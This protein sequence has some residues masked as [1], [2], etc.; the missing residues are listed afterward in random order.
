MSDGDGDDNYT[1]DDSDVCA[2]ANPHT[3]TTT[4]APRE[5]VERERGAGELVVVE[6][7]LHDNGDNSSSSSSKS[8]RAR[9]S[10]SQSDSTSS[11]TSTPSSST[12]AATNSTSTPAP[13]NGPAAVTSTT[14]ITVG[15]SPTGVSDGAQIYFPTSND[16]WVLN[17][18]VVIQWAPALTVPVDII[19]TNP[20]ERI[21]PYAYY[22]SSAVPP[23]FTSM[24]LSVANPAIPGPGYMLTLRDSRNQSRDYAISE[25]F[26]IRRSGAKPVVPAGF[27]TITA[28]DPEYNPQ[29][30]GSGAGRAAGPGLLAA[31]GAGAIAAAV[32]WTL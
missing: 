18:G 11:E 1:T 9:S 22:M 14:L 3:H 16:W 25:P 23:G 19:L 32:A 17:A 29:P 4:S 7:E 12:D 31:A 2:Y 8:T 21:M 28:V 6:F 24:Q 15:P 30:F 5:E 26:E 27:A 20:D 10:S 13:D